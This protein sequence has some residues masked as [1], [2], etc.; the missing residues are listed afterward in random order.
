MAEP[1]PIPSNYAQVLSTLKAEIRSARTRAA[2]AINAELV[3]LYWRIG[4]EIAAREEKEGWGAR[5]VDRLS[6]DLKAEFEGMTG[7]S[8]RNLRYMREL[9]KAWPDEA[10]MQRVVARLP[11]GHNLDLLDKV[12]NDNQRLFYATK[13]I[14]NDWTRKCCRRRSRP[15]STSAR[16]RR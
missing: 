2:L 15:S 16:A 10:M 9:A 6:A 8:P 3:T 7:L 4:Q 1:V 11:W 5:V 12:K 14:Q 13:A